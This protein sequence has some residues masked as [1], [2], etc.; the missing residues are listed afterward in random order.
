[1]SDPSRNGFV[2]AICVVCDGPLPAG[3]PRT[4]CSD[5]C[6]QALWRQRHRAA[7]ELATLVPAR[8]SRKDGTVYECPTCEARLVGEQYCECGSF[9]RRLGAGGY[10]PC[11]GEPVT[12]EEL[13]K[14]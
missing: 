4:T 10:S 9:M 14:G 6:R 12:V 11:C 7:P 3:R 8:R 2:T 5:R 13:L 1:M